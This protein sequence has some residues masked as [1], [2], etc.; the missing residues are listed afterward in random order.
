[1]V[2]DTPMQECN[3]AKPLVGCKDDS[4]PRRWRTGRASAAVQ[5]LPGRFKTPCVSP[6]HEREEGI[7]SPA[8]AEGASTSWHWW[9]CACVW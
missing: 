1:M 7:P 9:P 4:P 3:Q 8:A 6:F 5:L 2:G